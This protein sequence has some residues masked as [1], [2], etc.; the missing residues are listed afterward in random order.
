[1]R[2]ILVDHVRMRRAAKRGGGN[3]VTLI[4]DDTMLLGE[5]KRE[6]G[7]LALD[8]ALTRLA[9]L[10]PRQSQIVELRFFGGL[11]VEETARAIGIS[12][13]TVK[14]DWATARIWLHREIVTAAR[15]D[16]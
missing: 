6:L 13:A 10:D 3:V 14:R 1:M 11:S 9:S 16:T 4:H 2:G 7:L 15:D 5:K 8:E 12:Q